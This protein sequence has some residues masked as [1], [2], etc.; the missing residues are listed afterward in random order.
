MLSWASFMTLGLNSG[1]EVSS[2][3]TTLYCLNG[4]PAKFVRISLQA[5]VGGAPTVSCKLG[6]S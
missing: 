1:F 5:I 3:G 2:N 4:C 6:A